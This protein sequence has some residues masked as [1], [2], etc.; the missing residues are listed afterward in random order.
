MLTDRDIIF[1]FTGTK[2]IPLV[3][4]IDGQCLYDLPLS[5]EHSLIFLESDEVI[6]IS[7]EYP[8][9][10]GVTVRFIKNNEVLEDLQ[11]TEYFGSI[12]LSNPQVLNLA[13]YPYGC[14]VESPNAE[15][16]GE[17][18]II[19]DRDVSEW[20]PYSTLTPKS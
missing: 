5:Q 1:N 15:F 16:D 14:Y 3:W 8:D 20:L 17:K 12:L 2:G 19:T 7:E 10:D 18:F 4:V 11:T 13:E 6:D 9:H